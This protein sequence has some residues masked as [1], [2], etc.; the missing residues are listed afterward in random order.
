MISYTITSVKI[1]GYEQAPVPNTFFQ[2]DGPTDHLALIFPGYGYTPDMPALYYPMALLRDLGADVL[3]VRYD[4]Q[5]DPHFRRASDAE[6]QERLLA[7]VTS[8]CEAGLAQRTYQRLTLVGKSLGTGA[9][10]HALAVDARLARARCIWL[11][12][13]LRDDA[14]RATIRQFK[15]RS[16]FAIGTADPLYDAALLDEMCRATGGDALVADGADH[17]LEV[18]GD[19]EGSLAIMRNLTQRLRAFLSTP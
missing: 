7:D 19:I 6:R 17:I 14:L 3:Q 9:M 2:Q 13:I 15:P 11:T 10:A 8:A 18:P 12:P 1:A 4:Y 16:F 5:H